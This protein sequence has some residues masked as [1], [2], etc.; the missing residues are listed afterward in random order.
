MIPKYNEMYNEVLMVLNQHEEIRLMDLVNEVSNILNLSEEDRNE[1]LDNDKRT[2]IYY[3]LGWTKTY[4]A[5][6]GLLETV[7]RGV[8]KITSEGICV[9]NSGVQITNEYLMKYKSFVEFVRPNRELI[10]ENTVEVNSTPIE[11]I[12]RSL[13]MISS[14]LSDE[15]LEMILSKEPIFFERLVLD[16][17]NKMGYAFDDESVIATKY[18]GDEGIDGIIKEDKFGF[19]NIYIQAKRWNGTVGRPE[20]QK[21][22]GAVAGQGGSKGLFITTSSFTRDAIEFAKK[23]LQVKLILVDGKMLANLM[24]NYNLGVSVVKTYEIK[25]LDLDYFDGEFM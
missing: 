23:Q 6:A 19:S 7:R 3:R 5:K 9:L 1:T 16:L 24:I 11:S 14:R 17:L 18:T 22:L 10:E 20:I 15:L 12:D 21:F 2:V 8:F 25:Q 13:K 4:L